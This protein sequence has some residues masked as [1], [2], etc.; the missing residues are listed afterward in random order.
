MDITTL[1]LLCLLLFICFLA[2]KYRKPEISLPP[3]PKP[4]PLIGNVLHMP[5][6]RPWER[7]REWCETYS[8]WSIV[9][10][11]ENNNQTFLRFRYRIPA[12][13]AE[14]RRGGWLS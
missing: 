2:M 13:T 9:L 14:A 3:G 1:V 7:Y 12:F 5:T 10:A 6:V 8:W 4:W 11:P